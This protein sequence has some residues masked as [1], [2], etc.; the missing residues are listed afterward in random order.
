MAETLPESER[1]QFIKDN[2]GNFTNEDL[3][4]F[5]YIYIACDSMRQEAI[6]FRNFLF[7]E[8]KK[9][10]AEGN[11]DKVG[12]MINVE[13]SRFMNFVEK[14]ISIQEQINQMKYALAEMDKQKGLFNKIRNFFK[15]SFYKS[16][17]LLI[18]L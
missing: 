9:M 15:N 10:I 3:L 4:L 14:G 16:S 17:S 11:T 12:Y 1:E 8:A 2:T 5:Y 7:F 13:T 18:L 6:G